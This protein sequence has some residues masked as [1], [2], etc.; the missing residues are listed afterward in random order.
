MDLGGRVTIVVRDMAN[1]GVC[2]EAAGNHCSVSCG[3][4]YLQPGY[5]GRDYGAIH[6]VPMVVVPRSRTH[7][8]GAGSKVK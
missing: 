6:K 8:G 5:K 3:S 1:E 2:S 7:T 4:A